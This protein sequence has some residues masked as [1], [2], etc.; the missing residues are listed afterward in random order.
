MLPLLEELLAAGSA[1]RLRV[2]GRSMAPHLREGD[3]V[4]LR[5]VESGTIAAGEIL[6]IRTDAGQPVLHRVVG[7]STGNDGETRLLLKG[8]ALPAADD[9]IVGSRVIGAV[10]G[11]ERD[12]AGGACRSID[13]SGRG[14]RARARLLALASRRVP[15]LFLAVSLRLARP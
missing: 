2:T 11:L 10:I 6:L 4:T 9:P 7:R 8:D 13:F 5:R 12:E 15:R 1:V 3:V 14:H